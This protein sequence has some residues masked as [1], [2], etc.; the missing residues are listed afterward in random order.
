MQQTSTGSLIPPTMK[1]P[2]KSE[3][4]TDG[5]ACLY[6]SAIQHT[7]MHACDARDRTHAAANSDA[8]QQGRSSQDII[9]STAHRSAQ[10]CVHP[11]L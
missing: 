1:C 6:A 3:W 8:L 4:L 9:C 11:K 2:G 5:M 10:H 7:Y